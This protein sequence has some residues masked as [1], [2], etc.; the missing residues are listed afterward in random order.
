IHWMECSRQGGGEVRPPARK[1]KIYPA[2]LALLRIFSGVDAG[3][4]NCV[5]HAGAITH[6]ADSPRISVL[7]SRII[8]GPTETS[9]PRAVRPCPRDSRAPP[10]PR[11]ARSGHCH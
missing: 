2:A 6:Q 3:L 11:R 5:G 9:V 4:M 1:L 7:N 8:G 10:P